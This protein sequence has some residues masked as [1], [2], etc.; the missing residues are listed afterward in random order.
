MK[1][2]RVFNKPVVVI[3]R[4]IEFDAVRYSGDMIPSPEVAAMKSYISFIP[5]CPE[6]EIGLGI[7]RAAIRIVRTGTT[8]A[9]IQPSTG[10]DVTEAMNAFCRGFI[11]GLPVVDGFILKN[12]SPTSGISGVNIYSTT[13]KS[14]PIA[15]EAGF[16]GRMVMD[17]FPG[18][19]IED[20]G[21]IRN[22]RIRDHFLTRVF[23][24]A[25]LDQILAAP[26]IAALSRFH[27]HHKLSLMAYSQKTLKALGN[28]VANRERL[29]PPALVSQ[30]REV[31]ITGTKKPAPFSS[32]INVLLHALGYLSGDLQ[33][34]EKAFFLDMIEQYRAGTIPIIALKK[35]L[36]GWIIRYQ[37]EY[38]M[39]QTYFAPYPDALMELESSLI[40]RGREMYDE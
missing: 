19:P 33:A 31:L 17:T 5:V 23:M 37:P 29:S 16:F 21:R 7:P 22:F 27:A 32:H 20:E 13:E 30:Y 18:Y 2:K 11:N 26:S 1:Q 12:R 35:I 28:L 14:A 25:D 15:K 34:E 39:N 8:D 38:L 24:L 40:E 3:S 9:L 10:E 36:Q 4:C 6:V